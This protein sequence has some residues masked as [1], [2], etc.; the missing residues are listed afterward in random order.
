MTE[1]TLDVSDLEPPEPLTRTLEAAEALPAGDY[2]RMRHRR[3]PC[4]LEAQ[5]QARGLHCEIL[6]D[7]D[8]ERVESFIWRDHDHVAEA[9]ARAAMLSSSAS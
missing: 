1:R 7:D 8:D 5:L 3:Y 9:A 6:G 2:L 4:L